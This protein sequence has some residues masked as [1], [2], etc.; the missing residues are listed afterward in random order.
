[1]RS[2]SRCQK[3]DSNPRPHKW[4]RKLLAM[5]ITEG[6]HL[7]SGALDHSAILTCP[8]PIRRRNMYPKRWDTKKKMLQVRFELTT[9]AQLAPITAYK[10]GALTNCATGA[11]SPHLTKQVA[12][13]SSKPTLCKKIQVQPC[14]LGFSINSIQECNPTTTHCGGF[15]LLSLD[16]GPVHLSSD[17]LVTKGYPI[18]TILTLSLVWTSYQHE[19][20]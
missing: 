2:K 7:E 8:M 9:S 17:N 15:E 16:P 3:W 10:Y 4:T 5:Y 13:V 14:W 20:S 19:D 12:I 11:A 6:V 1:M 18:M